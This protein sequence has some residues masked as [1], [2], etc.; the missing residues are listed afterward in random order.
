MLL[1]LVAW[2]ILLIPGILAVIGL[3]LM[4]DSFFGTLTWDWL[5][6]VWVQFFCG[7]ILFGCGIAFIGGF[8]Y[9]RDKK[10]Q[11]G[12]KNSGRSP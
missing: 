4:R 12:K 11:Y 3:K 2:A 1:R 8:I 10:R 5:F 6:S 7:L 9:Y